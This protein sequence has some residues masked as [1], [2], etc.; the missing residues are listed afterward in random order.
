MP[1][2]TPMTFGIFC[3]QG[4]PGCLNEYM[5]PF[6]NEISEIINTGIIVNKQKIEVRV[7]CFI[8]DSPARAYLKGK[9][10]SVVVLLF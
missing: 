5:S 7:R 10:L 3:G 6:V 8:C 2:L 1:N 4:K 9:I